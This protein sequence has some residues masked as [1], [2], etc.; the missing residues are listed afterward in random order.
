MEHRTGKVKP[1]VV[2]YDAY[3]TILLS[4]KVPKVNPYLGIKKWL[5]SEGITVEDFAS[6]LMTYDGSLEEY[7]FSIAGIVIPHDVLNKYREELNEAIGALYPRPGIIK[8]FQDHL[9]NGQSVVVA[10]N[11]A[12][13]YAM[14]VQQLLHAVGSL[15]SR[16]NTRTVFSFKVGLLKPDLAFYQHIQS[17]FAPLSG[18]DFWMTGDRWKEDVWG[19]QQLGWDAQLIG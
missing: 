10:S 7:V 16:A 2:V 4:S 11:L 3:G 14:P 15:S 9:K 5:I 8:L 17:Q 13:D 1:K 12:K 18:K 6:S 19:P